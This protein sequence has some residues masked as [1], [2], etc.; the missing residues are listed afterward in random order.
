MRYA[1]VIAVTAALLVACDRTLVFSHYEHTSTSGWE[2][3]DTLTFCAGPLTATGDYQEEVGIRITGQY[4]FTSI[5][6]IVSQALLPAAP[7]AVSS[8]GVGVSRQDT[9]VCTLFDKRGA[10][11]GDGINIYQYTFPLRSMRAEKGERLVVSMRHDMKR[12]ILPGV[13]DIG[14]TLKSSGSPR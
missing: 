12:E 11:Q 7:P 2:R 8:Q 13:T 1:F 14:F 6:L 3:N 5:T 4:P 9:L 10:I